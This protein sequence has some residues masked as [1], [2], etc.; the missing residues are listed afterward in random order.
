MINIK[1]TKLFLVFFL[2][3]I[4]TFQFSCS[5]SHQ[6][7]KK[8]LNEDKNFVFTVWGHGDADKSEASWDSVF[9]KLYNAGITDYFLMA[10]P[11][12]LK[13][14]VHL[15]KNKGIRIHCWIWTLNRPNDTTAQKHPDWYSVNREGKNSLEA[16]PY[17]N[18]YQ[19]LSPFSEGATN[20]IKQNIR[21]IAEIDGL[22][23]VHLDYVRYCD[24]ILGKALQPKY[25]LVQDKEM[26]EYDFGYHPN[27]RK[28]IEKLFGVDPVKMEHP[29]LS[30][31]WRQFRLNAVT[32]L[33]NELAE[34]AHKNGKKIS[35]AVFP[36]PELARMNVRQDW[37][38]WNLDIAIPMV[39]QNFYQQ[40]LN[41]AGF[42]IEQGVR[43]VQNKFPIYAGLF[44]PSLTP[45]E[46]KKAILISKNSGAKGVSFFNLSSLTN[47]HLK[48]IW[49]IFEKINISSK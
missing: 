14:L 38:S 5:A 39:Y 21:E 44:I 15:T 25:N 2:S 18:Y 40:D 24:V 12:E 19:W 48:I 37:S 17:V 29:E 1:F 42:S 46:L 7:E 47:E 27:A 4:V 45:Q 35:A 31:E 22:A 13:R 36:Y 16:K 32:K 43:E 28:E 10:S 6:V 41:W 30:N 26:P 9:T 49:K 34:I 3:V 8:N 33:V 11:S 23:S 20:Y